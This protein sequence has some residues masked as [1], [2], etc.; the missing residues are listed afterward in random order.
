M[1]AVFDTNILIDYLNGIE[2]AA[3]VL[4]SYKQPLIS[5]ITW[6]EVL[7]GTHDAESEDGARAMLQTFDVAELDREIAEL[8]VLLR[9]ERRL[10]LPDAIILATAQT[11]GCLLITRNTKDFNRNWVEVRV[12]YTL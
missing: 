8:A 9:R 1:K 10:R 11:Q 5:R 7:A 12:P 6:M 2:K 3:D 4:S